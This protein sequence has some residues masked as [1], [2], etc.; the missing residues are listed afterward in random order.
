M[1]LA[2]FGKLWRA[3][4]RLDQR[5]FLQ[6]N[7]NFSVFF[8]IYKIFIILRRSNLKEMAAFHQRFVILPKF[9]RIC[10]NLEEF[11]FEA[12]QRYANLVD[13]EKC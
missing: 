5:R 10:K 7:I 3:R 2:C 12:V 11:E 1:V 4:S 13:L 8:E 9:S 6:P